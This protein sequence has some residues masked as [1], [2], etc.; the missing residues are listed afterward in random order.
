VPSRVC[1][2]CYNDIGGFL[3][4]ST[5]LSESC[6][7]ELLGETKTESRKIE[8][9]VTTLPVST[10]PQRQRERRSFVVDEL[11]LRVQSSVLTCS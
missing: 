5:I 9:D 3:T 2:R 6:E 10:R 1:D 11:A 8:T 7:E 4:G